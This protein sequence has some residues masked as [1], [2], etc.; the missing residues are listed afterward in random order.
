MTFIFIMRMLRIWKSFKFL[1]CSFHF[2]FI[3]EHFS[4]FDSI[5][6]FKYFIFIIMRFLIFIRIFVFYILKRFICLNIAYSSFK[7]VIFEM[8]FSSYLASQII[9]ISARLLCWFNFIHFFISLFCRLFNFVL[10]LKSNTLIWIWF[11]TRTK[12]G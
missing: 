9:R 7:W 4:S 6:W 10:P 3:Y 12:C 8:I 11:Y 2:V 1:K 5:L